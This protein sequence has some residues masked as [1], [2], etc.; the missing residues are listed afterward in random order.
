MEAR[1]VLEATVQLDSTRAEVY[2]L[3]GVV[4][5]N[6]NEPH[7]ATTVLERAVA[8][9]PGSWEDISW[10]GLAYLR[11]GNLARAEQ[12]FL[13]AARLA[14]WKPQPHL[15][16]ADLYERRSDSGR[17]AAH[18]RD[19][20]RLRPAED[21]VDRDLR[22]V[23]EFPM[24][25]RVRYSLGLDYLAQGRHRDAAGTFEAALQIDRTMAAAYHGLGAAHHLQGDAAAAIPFY[26][27]ATQLDSTRL[28][29]LADLARACF[30][31]HLFEQALWAYGRALTL[32]PSRLDL[33]SRRGYVLALAGHMDEGLLE[34]ER[35]LAA[36][37]RRIDTRQ[38]LAEV[39][40]AADR[41][42]DAIEQWQVVLRL[43]PNHKVAASRL[44]SLQRRS[45]GG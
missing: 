24:D 40:T 21:A 25:A 41:V 44:A 23:R 16:L 10:L 38:S 5:L 12:A 42:A 39:Y 11:L 9:T 2:R 8:L 28:T 19:F 1:H 43:D 26:L 27:R 33:R 14:P 20:E 22:Q 4:Y 37:G 34:L 29:A 15:H 6:Q 3:L 35:V 13:D 17:A 45:A 32:D 7:L 31:Q 30:E 18:R 36:D